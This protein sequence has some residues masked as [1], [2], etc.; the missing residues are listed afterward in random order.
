M[1][2]EDIKREQQPVEPI[3]LVLSGLWFLWWDKRDVGY[4]Q[5]IANPA[6]RRVSQAYQCQHILDHPLVRDRGPIGS[7]RIYATLKGAA[8]L[9]KSG[10]PFLELR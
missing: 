2:D 7:Q 1:K 9:Q 10:A 5:N 8:S 3:L 6:D 4:V